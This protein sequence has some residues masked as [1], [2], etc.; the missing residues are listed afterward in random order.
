MLGL[1]VLLN[2]FNYID[3]YNLPPVVGQIQEQFDVNKAQTGTLATGFLVV[4]MLT[5]PIFGWM[6]DRYSRWVLVGVGML[7]QSLGT[8]GSGAANTFLMLLVAR[9]V[10]GIGDAAYGPAAPTIISD[11]YPVERRGRVLA[12]FY[13]AMPVGSALG[14]AIGGLMAELT[15]SWRWGFYGIVGP[16]VLLGV[17]CLFIRDKRGGKTVGEQHHRRVKLADYLALLRNRSYLLNCAGMTAMTFAVGGVSYWMPVYLEQ[18]K[19]LSPAQSSI[20][21]GAILVLAGLGATLAGGWVGDR[22]RSRFSG[23]YFLVSGI[24]MIVA[25]PLVLLMLV[26]PFPACWGVIF[27]TVFALFFN[28]GPSN[29]ILANVTSPFVRASAFALNIFIIHLL[30]DAISPPLIGAIADAYSMELAF[31]LLSMVVLLSG[32]LWLIGARYLAADTAA[33]QREE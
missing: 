24:G 31:V 4:Y 13:A 1:L 27:L 22:L 29:T 7:I 5:A 10:V 15:G 33:A 11:L 9:C 18:T 32:V 14:Y 8:F 28:T 30:G 2:L 3:R 19:G 21:F 23:S 20:G 25:V 6:A 16:M 17:T 12:W 26:T